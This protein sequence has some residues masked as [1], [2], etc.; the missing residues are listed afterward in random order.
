[1][2]TFVHYCALFVSLTKLL[3]FIIRLTKNIITTYS[4]YVKKCRKVEY[5]YEIFNK[6]LTICEKTCEIILFVQ[7]KLERMLIVIFIHITLMA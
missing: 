6:Y 3:N 2:Y 1:M 5:K 4:C 7:D